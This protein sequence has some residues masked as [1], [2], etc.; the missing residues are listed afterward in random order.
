M[1]DTAQPARFDTTDFFSQT[2][3]ERDPEVLDAIRKERTR[4]LASSRH[5]APA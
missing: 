4:Q 3:E 2:L 1:A 5:G